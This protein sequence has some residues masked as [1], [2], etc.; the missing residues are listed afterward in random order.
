MEPIE[1]EL[2]DAVLERRANEVDARETP[3]WPRPIDRPDCKLES[4]L[5]ST[6]QS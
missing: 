3:T 6:G 4:K 2:P 5:Q 1:A